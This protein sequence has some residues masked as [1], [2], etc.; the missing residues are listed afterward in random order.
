LQ[1]YEVLFNNPVI[2]DGAPLFAAA[3]KNVAATGARPDAAS[4]RATRRL[5]QKQTDP[6]GKPIILP[7]KTIIC[8]PEYEE[9]F[10]AI[11]Q[12]PV[13]HAGDN[14]Q[15]KNPYYGFP[16]EI[17]ADPTLE[18]L[19]KTAPCPWFLQTERTAAPAIQVDYLDGKKIPTI[20]RFESENQ[21]GFTWRIYLDWGINVLDWRG[22]AMNP[23]VAIST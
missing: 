3:H 20:E 10:F 15:A 17:V 18:F 23:G 4:F 22:I 16:V 11:F 6:E 9:D 21:L 8:P 14:T 1:V 2:F 5:L 19:A 12:N 13:I 7:A